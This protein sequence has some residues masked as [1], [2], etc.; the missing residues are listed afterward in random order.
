MRVAGAFSFLQQLVSNV[1]NSSALLGYTDS[2]MLPPS[3]KKRT[4]FPSVWD[5]IEKPQKAAGLKARAEVAH[6]LIGEIDR[7]AL[8]QS[9]AAVLLGVTQPRV[10]DLMRGRL[11]L[12]SLDTLVEMAERVG[13]KV[14]IKL[15]RRRAA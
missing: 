5:A 13:F 2:C 11:D 6:V 14:G 7:R 8:T 9:R 10:S 15:S 4:R 1:D 3:M 12:F